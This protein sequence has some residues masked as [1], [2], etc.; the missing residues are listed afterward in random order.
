VN[1][2]AGT[3]DTPAGTNARTSSIAAT[4]VASR[5][6]VAGL[7]AVLAVTGTSFVAVPVGWFI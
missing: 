6:R 5:S 4:A 3:F 2:H 7:A 1:A